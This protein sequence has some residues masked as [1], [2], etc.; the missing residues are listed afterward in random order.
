MLSSSDSSQTLTN[1]R[2]SALKDRNDDSEVRRDS[3]L[4]VARRVEPKRGVGRV[5]LEVVQ[6]DVQCKC[7]RSSQKSVNL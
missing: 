3:R 7:L 2:A 4:E 1:P 5:Q 6:D